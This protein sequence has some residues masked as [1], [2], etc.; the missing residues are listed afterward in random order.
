M[1]ARNLSP[2]EGLGTEKHGRMAMSISTLER[3]DTHA[4][5]GVEYGFTQALSPD[6]LATFL[7]FLQSERMAV[8]SRLASGVAHEMNS[9][10]GAVQ[11]MR[12]TLSAAVTKL[13]KHLGEAAPRSKPDRQVHPTIYVWRLH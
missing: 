12:D 4:S 13:Q 6:E 5:V 1:K 2:H 9:P 10:I 8:L 7:N 11:S 3:T